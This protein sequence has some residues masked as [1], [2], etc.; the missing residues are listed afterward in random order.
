MPAVFL[1]VTLVVGFEV[2]VI[3]MWFEVPAFLLR[4]ILFAFVCKRHLLV[5]LWF[6]LRVSVVKGR[7]LVLLAMAIVGAVGLAFLVVLGA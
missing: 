4:L 2:P 5:E 3:L 1:V 6:V 7:R